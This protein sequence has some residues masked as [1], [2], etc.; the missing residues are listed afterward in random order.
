M[1][2]Y[3]AVPPLPQRLDRT[4]LFADLLLPVFGLLFGVTVSALIWATG[5]TGLPRMPAF[6][7]GC[8]F[9]L[10]A[11]RMYSHRYRVLG[12]APWLGIPA[13][14]LAWWYTT[15]D[16]WPVWAVAAFA[17]LEAFAVGAIFRYREPSRGD[18]V[19][20]YGLGFLSMIVGVGTVVLFHSHFEHTDEARIQFTIAIPILTMTL[21]L[22]GLMVFARPAVE[23][24]V[25]PWMRCMYQVEFVGPGLKNFPKEGPVLVMANHAAWFDPL[26]IAEAVPRVT[27]PMMTAG[28][29]D[30]PVLR[31]L[32]RRVFRVIRVAEKGARREAPEVQE[33]ISAI[34]CGRVVVIFPEG[35]L[36]RDEAKELRRFGRGVH[37]I[38]L[39]R[40]E[41]PVVACWIEGSWGCYFS[42]FNGPPTK[43]KPRD[44]RRA[45]RV[46]V[47]EPITIP[48][49][50]LRDHLDTRMHMMNLVAAARKPLGLPDLPPA[51]RPTSDTEDDL[52][53][54][55]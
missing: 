44:V 5:L 24:F 32:M 7:G 27:T 1:K 11:P 25:E 36:R 23:L 46:S 28:F 9:G 12:F 21:M 22:L 45:I 53:A 49:G 14:A 26:F 15:A 48:P 13:T 8:F 41:T 30:L 47:M 31:F 52:T 42:H 4:P 55:S 54:I 37:Q 6:F 17:F 33:A 43:N 19:R 38:L 10:L 29:Y 51:T 3:D 35:Y 50:M 16:V 2:K 20:H 40:P 18:R 39:A 34:D